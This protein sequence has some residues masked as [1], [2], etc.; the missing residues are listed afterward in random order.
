[1]NKA[2]TIFLFW[3]FL[4][5]SQAMEQNPN[6]L[7][8]VAFG[9]FR[10]QTE[11]CGC[12][13][14]TDLGGWERLSNFL[15]QTQRSSPD[16]YVFNLGNNFAK[17]DLQSGK[18]N[19][20]AASVETLR[21]SV[22]LFN[23]SESLYYSKNPQKAPKALY[24]LTSKG[25]QPGFV[26]THFVDQKLL[27]LGFVEGVTKVSDFVREQKALFGLYPNRTKILL[28][29]GKP[30]LVEEIQKRSPFD[31]V[32]LSNRAPWATVP[33]PIEKAEPG[34]L[35]AGPDAY[36]VPSFGQGVLLGGA[37][38]TPK[39]TLGTCS[40]GLL[41]ESNSPKDLKGLSTQVN[42]FTWLTAEYK[43]HSKLSS[44]MSDLADEESRLFADHVAQK[45]RAGV[46]G[47]Q[48]CASCH[49]QAFAK[50]SGS[51]HAQA[52]KNL[53]SD[54]Q[55]NLECVSC[56][57]LGL[58]AAGG[59][60]S[61]QKT[62]EFASVQCETCH[63]PRKEHVSNPTALVKAKP[64]AREVCASCHHLPHSA[65]FVFEEYWPKIQHGKD[66]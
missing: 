39:I 20:I 11:P 30:P 60:I 8:W 5:T 24:V 64:P 26:Q 10:G 23:E 55:T 31:A 9:D 52:Y 40:G 32:V 17:D 13:P 50:W 47:S 25:N 28:F 44:V 66:Q 63:G 14:A 29:A 19:T 51:Q 2:T 62:P 22:S 37:L 35:L 58:N 7:S 6:N 53:P 38:R 46:A 42:L 15:E 56:H 3:C 1:M 27:V 54:K 34:R 12:D 21:P 57:V 41:C 45:T 36:M 33:S 4:A 61:E 65:K 59:F 48:A 43:G 18:A 49:S 16:L